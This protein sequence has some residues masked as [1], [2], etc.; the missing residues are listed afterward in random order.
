[1]G[2]KDVY[3]I[4]CPF[5]GNPCG[6]TDKVMNLLLVLNKEMIKTLLGLKYTTLVVW[7]KWTYNSYIEE[8]GRAILPSWIHWLAS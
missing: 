7:N 6:V 4:E 5:I 2:K 1:M 3:D 8:L